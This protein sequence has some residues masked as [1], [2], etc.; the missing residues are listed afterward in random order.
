MFSQITPRHSRTHLFLLKTQ[1][2]WFSWFHHL[3]KVWQEFNIVRGNNVAER[4]FCV[5]KVN[6]FPLFIRYFPA[7]A[8]ALHK[9]HVAIVYRNEVRDTLCSVKHV[10]APVPC[11]RVVNA[12]HFITVQGQNLFCHGKD[13]RFLDFWFPRFYYSTHLTIPSFLQMFQ[14][15]QNRSEQCQPSVFGN[16]CP[17][18][19]SCLT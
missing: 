5:H 16:M 2:L 1:A 6:K 14:Y 18:S 7:R 17:A 11:A 3:Q 9:Q 13:F 15:P 10:S 8:F 19:I 12:I 4:H